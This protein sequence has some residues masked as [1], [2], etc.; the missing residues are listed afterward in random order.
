MGICIFVPDKMPLAGNLLERPPS[1]IEHQVLHLLR[2]CPHLRKLLVYLDQ[3]DCVLILTDDGNQSLKGALSVDIATLVF[4]FVNPVP[5]FLK[6][7]NPH[8]AFVM[9]DLIFANVIHLEDR[10]L[11]GQDFII[12]F[13]L[14]N[15]TGNL[16]NLLFEFGHLIFEDVL[17]YP[18]LSFFLIDKSDYN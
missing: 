17:Y 8:L 13:T 5:H 10:V 18:D 3:L 14:L 6:I 11:E 9:L 15:L 7:D 12:Q 16:Q 2:P 1:F 4:D